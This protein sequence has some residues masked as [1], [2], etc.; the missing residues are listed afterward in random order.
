MRSVRNTPIPAIEVAETCNIFCLVKCKRKTKK[1]K[2]LSAPVFLAFFFFFSVRRFFLSC[3]VSICYLMPPAA[4]HPSTCTVTPNR[5]PSTL[6]YAEALFWLLQFFTLRSL[7]KLLCAKEKFC[8]DEKQ[9]V[10]GHNNYTSRKM[11][12]D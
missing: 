1:K 9:A 4:S 10:E 8:T 11:S 3:I 2:S 7:T 5:L 12:A 6:P